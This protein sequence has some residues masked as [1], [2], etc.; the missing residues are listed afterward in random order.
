MVRVK[1]K[2]GP[3]ERRDR[4]A[5]GGPGG[6]VRQASAGAPAWRRGLRQA[7]IWLPSL[8]PGVAS[9]VIKELQTYRKRMQAY[10]PDHEFLEDVVL[11]VRRAEAPD[12]RFSRFD[13]CLFWPL[14]QAGLPP[15]ACDAPSRPPLEL[16]PSLPRARWPSCRVHP[17]LVTLT[18]VRCESNVSDPTAQQELQRQ[19]LAQDRL[20]GEWRKRKE[21]EAE[22]AAAGQARALL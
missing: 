1:S 4:S 19:T 16:E 18:S 5:P 17:H 9:E 14:R 6:E 11:G 12:D 22:P 7:L 3:A 15:L 20:N 8:R 2:A 10:S 13:P 21:A